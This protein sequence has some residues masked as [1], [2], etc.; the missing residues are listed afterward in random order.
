MRKLCRIADNTPY[1][2]VRFYD[3]IMPMGDYELPTINLHDKVSIFDP[4]KKK[5]QL[6]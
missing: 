1:E 6:A 4:E 5:D 2:E 3:E